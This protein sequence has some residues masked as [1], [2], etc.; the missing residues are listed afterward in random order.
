V[1]GTLARHVA[2]PDELAARVAEGR[3]DPEAAAEEL[4]DSAVIFKE[5]RCAG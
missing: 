2:V 5:L 4:L 3:C 1:L